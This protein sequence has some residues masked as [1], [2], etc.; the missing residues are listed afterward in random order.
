MASPGD[1]LSPVDNPESWMV[2]RWM[3]LLST[4]VLRGRGRSGK[5]RLLLIRSRNMD[6]R[7]LFIKLGR[8][9]RLTHVSINLKKRGGIRLVPFMFLY[10]SSM[11]WFLIR[12]N[13]Y[14]R[15][16][17]QKSAR[18]Q[19]N[20]HQ[21]SKILAIQIHFNVTEDWGSENPDIK[22]QTNKQ[23][24]KQTKQGKWIWKMGPKIDF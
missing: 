19:W 18:Y 16:H 5:R 6:G 10:N 22:K 23:T 15:V 17:Y 1:W 3:G 2:G 20:C 14:D 9:I 8:F 21:F 7:D 4:R 13:G 24:N 11:G 12:L